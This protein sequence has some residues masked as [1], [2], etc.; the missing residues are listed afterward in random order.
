MLAST[1]VTLVELA[2][3][4]TGLCNSALPHTAMLAGGLDV[5]DSIRRNVEY[6]GYLVLIDVV[7]QETEDSTQQKILARSG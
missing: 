5:H 4:V 3:L 6:R 7:R 2:G 1:P